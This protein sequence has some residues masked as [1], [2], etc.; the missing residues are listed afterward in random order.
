MRGQFHNEDAPVLPSAKPP[1]KWFK[2]QV[3]A[4]RRQVLVPPV[5][6]GEV[7][8]RNPATKPGRD[9]QQVV[10]S[11]AGMGGVETDP[12]EPSK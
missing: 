12:G 3:P 8:V 9:F 4:S 11:R 2:R 7:D 1:H 5:E 10:T 6:V